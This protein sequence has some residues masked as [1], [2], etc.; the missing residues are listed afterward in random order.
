M[1]FHTDSE[2]SLAQKLGALHSGVKTTQPLQEKRVVKANSFL[3]NFVST[4]N[5]QERKQTM[6]EQKRSKEIVTKKKKDVCVCI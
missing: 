6:E 3:K 1:C 5:E 2:K 4:A